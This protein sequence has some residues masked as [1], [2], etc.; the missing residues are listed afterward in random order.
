M[1]KTHYY[2]CDCGRWGLHVKCLARRLALVVTILLLMT[3]APIGCAPPAECVR[4]ELTVD[5]QQ[6]TL[7]TC[8]GGIGT[9]ELDTGITME[10]KV[11]DIGSRQEMATEIR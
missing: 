5:G 7:A 8:E 6:A 9:A 4:L 11:T 3:L 10:I 1:N 2:Y